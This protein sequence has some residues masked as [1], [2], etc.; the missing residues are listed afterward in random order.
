[1]VVNNLM[2][3]CGALAYGTSMNVMVWKYGRME[4]EDGFGM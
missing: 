4:W 2:Y 3:G 1:M